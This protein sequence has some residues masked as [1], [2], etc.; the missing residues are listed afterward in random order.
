M[1]EIL[2]GF[3]GFFL[4]KILLRAFI[5]F[6]WPVPGASDPAHSARLNVAAILLLLLIFKLFLSVPFH[7]WYTKNTFKTFL[8]I[9]GTCL[10]I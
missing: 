6:L 2:K 8:M 1:E 3:T 4:F 9:L 5:G 10:G 7:F